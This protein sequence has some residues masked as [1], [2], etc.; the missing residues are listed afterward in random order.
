MKGE[1][2]KVEKITPTFLLLAHDDNVMLSHIRE[3]I[4]PKY[5]WRVTRS[6]LVLSSHNSSNRPETYF[7]SSNLHYQ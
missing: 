4:S 3:T 1:Q 7:S 6:P 2:N 5:N